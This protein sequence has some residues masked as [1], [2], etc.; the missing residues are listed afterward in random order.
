MCDVQIIE[1][2]DDGR[3][4]VVPEGV[5]EDEISNFL[6]SCPDH[7]QAEIVKTKLGIGIS[8]VPARFSVPDSMLSELGE[9]FGDTVHVI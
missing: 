2:V 4:V 9:F 5:P 6:L 3:K 8:Y 7:F 1:A